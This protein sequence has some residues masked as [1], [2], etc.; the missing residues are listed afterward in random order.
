MSEVLQLGGGI[1]LIGFQELDRDE[2]LVVKKIVGSY[3]KKIA[4]SSD[5]YENVEV[6]LQK[7]NDSFS[8]TVKLINSSNIIKKEQSSSNVYV[9]LDDAMKKVEKEI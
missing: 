5:D 3:V 8:V 6:T 9:S 4:E 1:T 7:E 2:M